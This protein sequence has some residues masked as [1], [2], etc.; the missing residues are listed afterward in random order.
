MIKTPAPHPCLS[1]GACC[2]F[3]RVSFHYNETHPDSH[4]VP[5]G[6][7]EEIS[8]YMNAMNGTSQEK[9]SCVGLAGVVG[10]A[11]SCTIYENRPSCCRRFRASFEDGTNH[12]QCDKA[13]VGKGLAPLTLESWG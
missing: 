11:T 6:M 1:C 5:A 2:A 13:R 9:P 8:T 4:G 12:S 3:F 7:S 10:V